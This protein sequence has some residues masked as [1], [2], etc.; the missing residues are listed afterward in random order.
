MTDHIHILISKKT[1]ISE[2]EL[3]QKIKAN[4][5]R[6]LKKYLNCNEFEWQRGYGV[7][8]YNQSLLESVKI[9]IKNQ[10]EHH[11]NE[12]YKDEMIMYFTKFEIPYTEED[13]KDFLPFD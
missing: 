2:A 12:T 4:S 8:S 11:K 5:S 13:L 9:Y 1:N 7:F 6:W 3:A 10:Q